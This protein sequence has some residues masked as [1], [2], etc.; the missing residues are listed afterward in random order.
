MADNVTNELLL[1]NMKAIQATLA[2]HGEKFSRVEHRL[3][4]LE[5]YIAVLV[6]QG[7]D[8]N[9]DFASLTARVDRIERRLSLSDG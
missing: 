1:E 3:S 9:I 8:T 4:T 6:K 5:G 7:A 2:E